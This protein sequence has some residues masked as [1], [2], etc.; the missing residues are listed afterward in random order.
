MAGLLASEWLR[1]RSVRS[2]T[3]VLTAAAGTVVLAGLLT[4]QAGA[5]TPMEQ[6]MAP[7]V[8]VCLAVLGVLAMGAEY[9]TGAIRTTLVA[10][11]G[12]RTL[13]AARAVVVAAVSFAVTLAVVLATLLLDRWIA[14]GAASPSGEP[15]VLVGLGLTGA[16]VAVV[17]LGMATVL[18]STAGAIVSVVGLLFVLPA[19]AH[20]L[21]APWD[22]RVGSAMLPSLAGEL[23]GRGGGVDLVTA[24]IGAPGAGAGGVLPPLGALALLA[25]Y[26]AVALAA[27]ATA[28]SL[29]DA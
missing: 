28:I 7:V 12:R 16:V 2:T 13:I 22:A 29:R 25:A 24:F 6:V 20:L 15:R 18:R 23:A 3:Y 9:A 5:A 19:V 14:G 17:G 26:A 1:L 4:L 10:V 11:P 21:P 8:Q 27:A